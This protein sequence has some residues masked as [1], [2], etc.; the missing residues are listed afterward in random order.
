MTRE[1]AVRI[2]DNNG[3]LSPVNAG[4]YYDVLVALPKKGSLLEIG[5]GRGDSALFFSLVKPEWIIYTVDSYKVAS[6]YI[7]AYDLNYLGGTI[8]SLK[9][10]GIRN[11]LPIIANSFT[12]PWE[13]MVD[14][15]Y[16]DGDH[17]YEAIKSDFERFSPFV[18][19]G[20]VIFMDDYT[21]KDDD[22]YGV[23][24]YVNEVLKPRL[25][26]ELIK[27]GSGVVVWPK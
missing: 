15:L 16:I 24:Q 9:G 8:V 6:D 12:M 27:G 26:V 10:Q 14:V 18:K 13:T 25:K 21:L 1:E 7:G 3:Y 23:Y 5:T 20:G 11:I 17:R 4:A 19:K 22:Y 2:A